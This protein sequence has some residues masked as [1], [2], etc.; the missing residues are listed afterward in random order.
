MT[1]VD[2]TIR[3]DTKMDS[4]GFNT[5]IKNIV[6]NLGKLL[7][8]LSKVGAAI[9]ITFG[10]GAIAMFGRSAVQAASELSSAMI[11]LQSIADG[12]GRSFTQAQ[13]I[14][15]EYT[16]DG[17]I[18]ATNAINAYKNLALRGYDTSQ[19]EQTLIALKDASAFSRQASYTMGEA[20]QSATEGLKNENSILVDNAGVTKNVAKM[21][22]EYAASIGTTANA[23]TQQQKIQAEV[24]GIMQ[25]TRFQTGDAAKVSNTYAGVTMGLSAAFYN[26]KV[27][28]GNIFMPILQKLIPVITNAINWLTV[29]ANTIAR[30]IN[31][32]FGTN[33]SLASTATEMGNV[34]EK[35]AGA[36]GAQGKLAKET[37]AAGKAAKGALAAFDELNVL[38]QETPSPDTGGA[39]AGAG[40]GAGGGGLEIPVPE[41]TPFTEALDA[42]T[43]KVMAFKEKFLEFIEPLKEPFENL[44]RVALELGGTIWSGLQ[45]VWENI[46][47]PFGTWLVQ[48]AAPVFIDLLA[49]GL[50]V[51]NE[52][53]KEV[54]PALEWLW[55]NVLQPLGEWTGEAFL[56]AIT[57]ITEKLN[58]AAIIISEEGFMGLLR[59]NW[60]FTVDFFKEALRNGVAILGLEFELLKGL[61]LRAW[62]GI[63][64]GWANAKIWFQT[65][66]ID[67]IKKGFGT[68]LDWIKEKWETVFTGVQEFVKTSLNNVIDF[69]NHLIVAVTTALNTIIDAINSL[70]FS[71]PEGVPI[72]GGMHWGFNLPKVPVPQIPRLATGAVIPP[73]SEFLAILGDQTSGRN[74]E[75]P[76]SL[77]RQIIQEELG[78]MQTEVTINFGG[79]LGA[80]VRELKPYID[81]ENIRIGS[82]LIASGTV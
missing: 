43:E 37:K 75:A 16:K 44:K 18:P 53:L 52:V 81:K 30:V 9:G 34:E 77:I 69:I 13:K 80:L 26:L 55:F 12:Q 4:K 41:E 40:V 10:I 25:E 8:V 17:L 71:V 56:N 45:W 29:L 60:Q 24:A 7:G 2:G 36:A 28:V 59:A 32:L 15:D 68:A 54:G 19:I 50:N 14:I 5:G 74:I 11:G 70:S 42:L 72:W 38:Q 23:L 78:G 39:G 57:W 67:P 48:A 33:I 22:Q 31:I 3:I 61:A 49:A 65:V 27:A 35:T 46:L 79:S 82:S 76:E 51:L 66:V 21:W 1:G 6:G 62:E 47:V 64:T 73:N 20:V 63:K 58:E